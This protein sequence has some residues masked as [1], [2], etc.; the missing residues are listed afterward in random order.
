MSC[1]AAA[2]S[3][4]MVSAWTT[5]ELHCLILS[6]P[7]YLRL[8]CCLPLKKCVRAW[9]LPV[10]GAPAAKPAGGLVQSCR[11]F[12]LHVTG[13][14]PPASISQRSPAR[15]A[16]PVYKQDRPRRP[17]QLD[18]HNHTLDA[19]ACARYHA[20]AINS[21]LKALTTWLTI[22]TLHTRQVCSSSAELLQDVAGYRRTHRPPAA[23]PRDQQRAPRQ[24]PSTG[25]RQYTRMARC[26]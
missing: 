22:A 24:R 4:G 23:T 3:G 21:T 16:S 20:L 7:F 12:I 10:A 11:L 17:S 6:M 5:C 15:G 8:V 26:S 14:A 13:R 1:P 25:T 18:R 9:R 2:T 19:C